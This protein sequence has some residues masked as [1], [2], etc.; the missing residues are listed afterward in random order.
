MATGGLITNNGKNWLLNRAYK[1]TTDYDEPYYLKIGIGLTTPVVTDTAMETPIP[2]SNGTI[3]DDGS[4]TLTGSGGGSNSTDNTTTY[5]QGGN[6]VDVTAQNLIATTGSVNKIWTIADLDTAGTIITDSKYVALWFYIK[7]AAALAKL[8][9]TGTCLEI[10][11]GSDSSNYYSITKEASDLAV[12]WNW[13]HSYPTIVSGLTETGTVSGSV[14]TL[15]IKAVTGS[16]TALFAAGDVVYDLLRTYEAS[17]LLKAIESGYPIFNT[18]NKTATTR[19][20]IPVTEANG[21]D[22]TEIGI[23]SK[24]TV[25]IMIA[26]D[27]TSGESKT[28]SDEFRYNSTDEVQ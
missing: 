8:A 2:I 14:D 7:N 12:G 5:K 20:K 10:K 28:K 1:A 16:A 24:D 4:N 11:M 3:N 18:T 25:P 26:H 21:F 23:F 22:I 27:V 9:S 13:I 6:V 19:F 17:D 15:V